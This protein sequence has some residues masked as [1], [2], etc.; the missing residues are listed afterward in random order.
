MRYAATIQ[1][2]TIAG[3]RRA[4]DSRAA[5]REV[6]VARTCVGEARVPAIEW[7]PMENC[8]CPE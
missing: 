2:D 3:T 4:V 7:G 1:V 5:G 8:T 6:K